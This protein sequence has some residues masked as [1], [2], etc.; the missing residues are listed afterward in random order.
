MRKA[1]SV[2]AITILGTIFYCILAESFLYWN[3]LAGLIVSLLGAMVF[4]HTFTLKLT[5]KSFVS[6]AKFFVLLIF[7][8][9]KSAIIVIRGMLKQ[10]DALISTEECSGEISCVIEANS[11][12]LTPGTVVLEQRGNE[13]TVLSFDK[14]RTR[15]GELTDD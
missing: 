3:V 6:N 9:Y 11:I 7:N 14:A 4:G 15:Q 13:L 8:I 12:S 10:R 1:L 2:S 5:K